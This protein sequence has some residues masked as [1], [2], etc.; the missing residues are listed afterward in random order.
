[1]KLKKLIFESIATWKVVFNDKIFFLAKINNK[2]NSKSK[3][4][5]FDTNL[6]LEKFF[7]AYNPDELPKSGNKMSGEWKV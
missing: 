4:N 6:I 3:K 7:E 1:M 2:I 5:L